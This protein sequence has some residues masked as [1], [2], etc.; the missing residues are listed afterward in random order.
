MNTIQINGKTIVSN[1]KNISVVNNRVKIDG[2]T[3]S[4]GDYTDDYNVE[5]IVNGDCQDI[6]TNG[7]VVCYGDINGDIDCNGSVSLK[8]K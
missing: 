5:I 3:F 1:G 2:K 8:R 6:D 4:I 7:S